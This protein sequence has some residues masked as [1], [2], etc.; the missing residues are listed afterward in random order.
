MNPSD[1]QL[2]L[3]VANKVL[4]LLSKDTMQLLL[5]NNR[6]CLRWRNYRG[7]WQTKKWECR[8]GSFFPTIHHKVPTGGTHITAITQLVN[9]VNGKPCLPIQTWQYW[10]SE[11]VGMKPV[12][13]VDILKDSDYPKERKCKWCGATGQLDWYRFGNQSGLG[14]WHTVR[15]APLSERLRKF[16]EKY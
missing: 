15:C 1:K 16:Q 2:R 5:R 11:P 4:A 10:C 12:E 3:D 9:W 13:V 6:V 8:G 14:C 7:D